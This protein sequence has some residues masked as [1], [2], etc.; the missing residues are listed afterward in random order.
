MII[1]HL[2]GDNLNYVWAILC[3]FSSYGFGLPACRAYAVYLGGSLTLE[4]MQGI[5]TDVFLR[6]RQIDGK[7]ESFRI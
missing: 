7:K 1:A 2:V 3:V 6:L 4:S 5:G